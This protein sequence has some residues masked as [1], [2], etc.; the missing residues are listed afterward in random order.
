MID[1]AWGANLVSSHPGRDGDARAA[2]LWAEPAAGGGAGR[3]RGGGRRR[4]R[5]TNST[6]HVERWRVG[7]TLERA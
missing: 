2:Q 6:G 3:R 5:S 4:E 7:S 1:T